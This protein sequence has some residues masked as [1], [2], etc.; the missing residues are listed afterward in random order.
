MRALKLLAGLAAAVLVHLAGLQLY[1]GFARFIDVFLVVVVLYALE[2]ETLSAIFVGMLVGLLHDSLSGGPFGL[3]GF[4]DTIV[5]Y[6]T[7]RLA[8]HLVIQ[9]ATGVLGVV[10]FASALQQAIVVALTFLLLPEPALPEPYWVAVQAGACGLVGMAAYIA[11]RRWR[12]G[13]DTRRRNRM[14]RLRLS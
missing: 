2:G 7:A 6:G 13:M 12:Q 5:G 9:R 8:Q 11:G 4:A 3:F 1:G 10:A 14:S